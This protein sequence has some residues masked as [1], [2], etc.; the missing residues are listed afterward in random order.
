MAGI[1]SS[2]P[3]SGRE[4]DGLAVA[5]GS[6]LFSLTTTL[7]LMAAHCN[8]RLGEVQPSPKIHPLHSSC[9]PQYVAPIHWAEEQYH[10]ANTSPSPSTNLP[11]RTAISI[12]MPTQSST[13]LTSG[14]VF[15]EQCPRQQRLCTLP[16][17]FPFVMEMTHPAFRKTRG[18]CVNLDSFLLQLLSERDRVRIDGCFGSTIPYV[19]ELEMRSVT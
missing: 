9:T 14:P 6:A 16:G 8:M 13:V 12:S 11:G 15:A 1:R 7:K 5:L 2:C 18:H 4:G 3:P 10:Q 19:L 17:R